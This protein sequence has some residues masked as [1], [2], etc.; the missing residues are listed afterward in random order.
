MTKYTTRWRKDQYPNS[1]ERLNQAVNEVRE[2][3]VRIALVMMEDGPYSPYAQMATNKTT[4]TDPI[5]GDDASG[6]L[7]DVHNGMHNFIGGDPYKKENR[8]IGH[9]M[10]VSTAAFDPIFFFHHW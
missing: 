5:Y 1:L 7:E 3:A 10:E 2:D 6:S 9:M 8:S 4:A